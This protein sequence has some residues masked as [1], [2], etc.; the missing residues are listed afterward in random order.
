MSSD[1]DSEDDLFDLLSE[2]C[3]LCDS[4]PGEALSL[5]APEPEPECLNAQWKLHPLQ[6]ES[7]ITEETDAE[8]IAATLSWVTQLSAKPGG[9]QAR[10]QGV[11]LRSTAGRGVGIFALAGHPAGHVAITLG[12][13]LTVSHQRAMEWSKV[14]NDIGSILDQMNVP[15]TTCI[16]I[17]LICE[18]AA[19]L[20]ERTSELQSDAEHCTPPIMAGWVA[21]LPGYAGLLS[22]VH[23][24]RDGSP[25]Q[26]PPSEAC[27]ARE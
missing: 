24:L 27:E 11:E 14:H 6:P 10:F 9:P 12:R 21:S 17:F 1:S 18:R 5:R 22:P 7:Q 25:A 16:A 4:A 3:D 19:A 15:V 13:A 23:A 8:R 2:A 20:D 26:P